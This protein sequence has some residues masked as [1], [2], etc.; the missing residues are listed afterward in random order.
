MRLEVEPILD[1]TCVRSG[2][3]WLMTLS[4]RWTEDGDLGGVRITAIFFSCSTLKDLGV[5]LPGVREP[6]VR[7][8]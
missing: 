6:G 1:L 4:W 7:Q 3:G 8:A 2:S 5:W